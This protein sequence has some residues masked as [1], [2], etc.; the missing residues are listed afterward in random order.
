MKI[1][2][3]VPYFPPAYAFGGPVKVAYQ[4]SR[5]LIK[6]GHEVV[7][8]TSDAG[9]FGSRLSVES[10]KFV[11]GITVQYFRNLA[12]M[13]VKKFK[14]FITPQLFS[15]AKEEVEKFD[16][17]HLHEYRTFQNIVV[18]HYAKKYGVPYVL[19]ARGSLPRIMAWQRLKWVYDVLFG[20]RLLRDA[21]KVIALTQ[22]EAWQYRAMGVPE[23]KIAIIPNGIDLLDYA[24]LPPKGSFRKKFSVDDD[25][26]I[27]LYL[28]RIHK[29][30]GLDI[31][32]RA[33]AYIV[34]KLGVDDGLLVIAGVDDGYLDELERLLSQLRMANNVL[35]TGPLYGKDKLE[36]YVDADVFVLPSRY[37]TFP[38]VVLE[39]YACS[40]P[41][42]A[43]NVESIS[44][45]VIQ[46]KNGLLFRSGDVQELAETIS[47][48]LT[49]SEEAQDM[50]RRAR[51]VVE[52]KFSIDKVVDSLE[53]LYEKILK[54]RD[55][56]S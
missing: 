53:A 45:I 16:V 4:V 21:S 19:Q 43:S 29:I 24:D 25:K 47:Y 44:D 32:V 7:V 48:V 34:N 15:R 10:V 40:K 51:K 42:I 56:R 23:E 8:Y 1:L 54:K 30:K 5:E 28:G 49:H 26:K 18:A 11:D 31:L 9:D 35:F 37:E 20:Y 46:G 2:Q 13:L 55:K 50:G 22:T 17:I 38:N 33:Y 39:A 3:V 6:R 41:V 27:I 12:L 36:A 14:L 52:E